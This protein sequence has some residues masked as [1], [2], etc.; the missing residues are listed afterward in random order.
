MPKNEPLICLENVT[1]RFGEKLIFQGL[2]FTIRRG[3]HWALTGASGSGKTALL[4]TLAGNFYVAAGKLVRV[5]ASANSSRS[6]V[7]YLSAKYQFRNLS[8]TTEFF[9]Q[10]RFNAA[11]SEDAPSVQQYLENIVQSTFSEG[12]WDIPTVAELFGL[13]ELASRQL[14]K[15]SNGETKR[16]RIASAL[17]QNPVILLLDN[18]LTG[19]DVATRSKF[20]SILHAIADSGITVVMTSAPAEIPTIITHAAELE[21]CTIK[22]TWKRVDFDKIRIPE[23]EYSTATDSLKELVGN[24][25]V[26]RYSQLVSLNGVTVK[27][28][29]KTILE[30]ISWEVRQGERWAL[31]GPN[32]A[33][34]S[35]LLSLITGDNPQA[36]ANDVVLFDRQRGTGE[37]IWDIKRLIGFVSPE[38]LQY[39]HTSANCRGVVASGFRDSMSPPEDLSHFENERVTKWMAVLHLQHQASEKFDTMSPTVQRMTLIAR[40]LVKN[41]PL[42]ILDEPCQGLDSTQQRIVRSLVDDV[43]RYSA[44]TLIYVTH[45]EEE[46]P[47]CVTKKLML[48]NGRRA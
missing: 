20:D 12:H 26:A 43:C 47:K 35:T 3:E 29:Q 8:N 15:L 48:N 18:P 9:Y 40:A 37:S 41:P 24:S 23:Q 1:A 16:L 2:S 45:Y 5:A 25:S 13:S 28:G 32:G 7:A 4:E 22:K 31:Q 30:N 42:L 36:Y 21:N 44:A 39:F 11:F 10:Q 34:K 6:F 46:L 27:Y 19:L 17:L 33:G 14:I 38:L